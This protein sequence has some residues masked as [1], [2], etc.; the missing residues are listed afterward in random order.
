MFV[1]LEDVI[2]KSYH[3]GESLLPFE[4]TAFHF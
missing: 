1:G 3:E 2:E 4:V